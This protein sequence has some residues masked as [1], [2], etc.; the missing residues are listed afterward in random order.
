MDENTKSRIF[1]P[2]FTTKRANRGLGMAAAHGIVRQ[3]GGSIQ[4]DSRQGYGTVVRVL[5]PGEKRTSPTTLHNDPSD[6]QPS[7]AAG[8]GVSEHD[9]KETGD[10]DYTD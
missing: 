5:L 9:R 7:Q 6:E 1:D 2:F 10:E 3:H 4:V 8:V